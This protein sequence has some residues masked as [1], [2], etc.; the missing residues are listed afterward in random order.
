MPLNKRNQTK[1]RDTYESNLKYSNCSFLK[2]IYDNKNNN[3]LYAS[4]RQS[5]GCYL[6]T[7]KIVFKSKLTWRWRCDRWYWLSRSLKI[8]TGQLK[9]KTAIFYQRKRD[10]EFYYIIFFIIMQIAWCF[11]QCPS[12]YYPKLFDN[13]IFPLPCK[14]FKW[15]SLVSWI[16]VN[17]CMGPSVVWNLTACLTQ[18]NF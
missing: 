1:P 12:L 14:A 5:N 7:E 8:I 18:Q 16:P 17:N 11:P 6:D 15:S 4:D 3:F 13:F 9:V 2:Y 10:N